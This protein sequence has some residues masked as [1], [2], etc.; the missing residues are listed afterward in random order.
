MPSPD[1][2][3]FEYFEVPPSRGVWSKVPLRLRYVRA[4][5]VPEGKD[6]RQW[7]WEEYQR[8]KGKTLSEDE[9]REIWKDPQG[10]E[11]RHFENLAKEHG[12]R[13]PWFFQ[14]VF[15]RKHPTLARIFRYF[16]TLS[17]KFDPPWNRLELI[18]TRKN[19]KKEDA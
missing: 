3:R 8:T 17:L 10:W 12:Y 19:P 16:Y 6:M 11:D 13:R 14:S 4:K 1:Q 5:P 2:P 9:R 15:Y 18:I 7:L